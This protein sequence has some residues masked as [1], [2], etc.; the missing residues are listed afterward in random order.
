MQT[1]ARKRLNQ[2]SIYRVIKRNPFLYIGLPLIIPIVGG[3]FALSYLTQTRYE[4]HDNKSKKVDK[5][6]KLRINNDR[7]RVNLQEEYEVN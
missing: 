1:F 5:E 4:L 6:E 7:R 2:P 3:S